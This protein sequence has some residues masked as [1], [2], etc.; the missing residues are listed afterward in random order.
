[1]Q[2][3]A[4]LVAFVAQPPET[5]RDDSHSLAKYHKVF[6]HNAYL[7][8][9]VP[10]GVVVLCSRPGTGG[11][12][13]TRRA[14]A[15]RAKEPLRRFFMVGGAPSFVGRPGSGLGGRSVRHGPAVPGRGL[16]RWQGCQEQVEH[17]QGQPC[18]GQPP[19][20]RHAGR[21][22]VEPLKKFPL[23]PVVGRVRDG[24]PTRSW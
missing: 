17:A 9:F 15:G 1:M 16:R 21:R 3:P 11:A 5:E 19:I 7:F 22:L 20:W 18:A 10:R 2:P 24:R 13:V 8:Q 12:P 4:D 23:P 14:S 6:P